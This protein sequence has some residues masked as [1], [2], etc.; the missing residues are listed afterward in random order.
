M[1]YSEEHFDI[2]DDPHDT[3][4]LTS[5]ELNRYFLSSHIET[6]MNEQ[7]NVEQEERVDEMM[8]IDSSNDQHNI[9][10]QV[11]LSIAL[12]GVMKTGIAL[13]LI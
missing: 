10:V 11:S 5:E 12:N 13:F 8:D 1:E 6:I 2:E 3:A 4:D 9:V 7:Y